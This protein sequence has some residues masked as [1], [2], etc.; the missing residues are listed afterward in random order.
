MAAKRTRK[1]KWPKIVI[2]RP[3]SASE[4][5][6]DLNLTEREKRFVA[7][8]KAERLAREANENGSKKRAIR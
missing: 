5:L 8:L 4:I 1:K 7:R 3:L 6:A 2:E